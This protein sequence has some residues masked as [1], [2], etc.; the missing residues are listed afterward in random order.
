MYLKDLL[1]VL[2]FMVIWFLVHVCV[3]D[4]LTG[5]HRSCVPVTRDSRMCLAP[6]HEDIAA[7]ST[8]QTTELHNRWRSL[9]PHHHHPT[10]PSNTCTPA[11]GQQQPTQTALNLAAIILFGLSCLVPCMIA[12]FSTI[13]M[14]GMC[15]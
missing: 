4:D 12:P 10:A 6:T 3:N 13:H 11:H 15:L 8:P 2:D 9:C 7:Q 14:K 5:S 1:F